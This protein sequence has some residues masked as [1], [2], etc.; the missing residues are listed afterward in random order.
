MSLPRNDTRRFKPGPSLRP[1]AELRKWLDEL[2]DRG[3]ER[4]IRLP[5]RIQFDSNRLSVKSATVARSI[6]DTSDECLAV[7]LKFGLG[8]SIVPDLRDRCHLEQN[9]CYA[10][11][12]GTAG[13]EGLMLDFDEDDDDEGRPAFSVTRVVDLI[14][15]AEP[16]P[17]TA[18]IEEPG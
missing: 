4:R 15:E 9:A 3:D 16:A 1:A 14:D 18:L 10:W 12:E 6:R 11:I 5:L 8:K 13:K 7:E 2:S 17:V